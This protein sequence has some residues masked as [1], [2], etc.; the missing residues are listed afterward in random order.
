MSGF[1]FTTITYLYSGIQ[2][3]F[4]TRSDIVFFVN[5]WKRDIDTIMKRGDQYVSENDKKVIYWC[6]FLSKTKRLNMRIFK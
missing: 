3:Y 1:K 4:K 5:C 6:N 2:E